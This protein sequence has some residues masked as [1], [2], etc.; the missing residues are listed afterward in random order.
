MEAESHVYLIRAHAGESGEEL[1]VRGLPVRKL[2]ELAGLEADHVGYLSVGRADGSSVYLQASDFAE[3]PPF[4][5]GLPPVVWVDQNATRFLRPLAGPQDANA[6]DNIATPGGEALRVAIRDGNLL[7]VSATSSDGDIAAGSAVTFS[8]SATG[9]RPGERLS[10]QWTF[11]DGTSAEGAEVTH[12]FSGSG[13]YEVRATATGREESGGEAAPL[14]IVVGDPPQRGAAGAA[15]MASAAKP[16]G[17]GGSGGGGGAGN[18]ASGSGEEGSAGRGDSGAGAGEPAG[19]QGREGATDSAP[20]GEDTALAATPAAVTTAAG[21]DATQ[22]QPTPRSGD[23]GT[24]AE[25]TVDGVLV[26]DLRAP[27]TAS[28]AASEASAGGEPSSASGPSSG[29]GTVPVAAL[30]VAALLGAGALLEWRGP[31]LRTR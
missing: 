7:Q 20:A 29:G 10:F 22:P 24:A 19:A 27:A 11:G 26:A 21:A 2:I 31:R 1:P 9:A 14:A 18:G 8:A 17:T 5:G 30:L 28:A 4:E 15:T 16:R 12:S 25:R 6:A 3:P 23:A 13:T